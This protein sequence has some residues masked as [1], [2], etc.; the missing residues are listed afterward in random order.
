MKCNGIIVVSAVLSIL[1]IG[2]TVST[3]EALS[4]VGAFVQSA[5]ASQEPEYITFDSVG[6]CHKFVKQN[7]DL[8]DKSDCQKGT[9]PE[10][11]SD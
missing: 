10:E 6:D 1:I 5:Y 9:P 4:A 8:Y 2:A 7:S 11:P 3:V